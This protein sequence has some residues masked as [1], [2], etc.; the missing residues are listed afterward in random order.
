MRQRSTAIPADKVV[1][2]SREFTLFASQ[3]TPPQL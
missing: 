1:A 2:H 3:L